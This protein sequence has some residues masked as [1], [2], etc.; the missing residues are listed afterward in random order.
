MLPKAIGGNVKRL[1]IA[2]WAVVAIAVLGGYLIVSVGALRPVASTGQ[3]PMQTDAIGGPFELVAHTGATVNNATLAGR[4]YLV[5]F[6]FTYC[7]DI[8]PTTLA[9]LTG[10]L[11]ELGTAANRLVPL[12]ITVDPDRDTQEMLDG[13]MKAFD[14]RILALRGNE[15]MTQAAVK[16]FAAY[17]RKV[18]LSG[19]SYTMDHTAGVFLMSAEGRLMSTL[20]MHEPHEVRLAKLRRLLGIKT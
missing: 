16:A 2:V 6:G 20:D 15:S 1:R 9:E 17:V 11:N 4:P 5:F 19:G 10:L 18:P 8:C 13:Y 12:F 7:P 3:P 14:S